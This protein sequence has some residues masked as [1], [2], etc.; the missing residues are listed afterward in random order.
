MLVKYWSNTGRVL[1]KCPSDPLS[2]GRR[3]VCFA[4]ERTIRFVG[5]LPPRAARTCSFSAAAATAVAAWASRA[6]TGQ[7]PTQGGV[8][9]ATDADAPC[10]R[11]RM[12]AHVRAGCNEKKSSSTAIGRKV[13]EIIREKV[14]AG[15][16][17]LLLRR[18]TFD[19]E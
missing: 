13:W 15:G 6:K 7:G 19:V 11:A 14:K 4:D 10:W 12:H 18:D 9:R 3:L 2:G 16:R 8:P 17:S 5:M 1:V